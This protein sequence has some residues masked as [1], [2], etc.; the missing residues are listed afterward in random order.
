[1]Y[2]SNIRV[3]S[4]D[5]ND[6]GAVCAHKNLLSLIVLRKFDMH[7]FA[8]LHS[9]Y[10]LTSNTIHTHRNIHEHGSFLSLPP[11]LPYTPSARTFNE[12]LGFF[13][14]LRHFD[15]VEEKS[16]FFASLLLLNQN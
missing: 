12:L 3:H 16:L 1:M 14:L 4:V 9:T 7:V 11:F 5:G 6:L 13:L 2:S 10:S 8:L 15:F